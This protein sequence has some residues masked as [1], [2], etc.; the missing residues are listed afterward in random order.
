MQPRLRSQHGPSYHK[1]QGD[2]SEQRL[3]IEIVLAGFSDDPWH[4]TLVGARVSERDVDFSLL[5][6]D[7]IAIVADADD[8]LQFLCHGAMVT[9][10]PITVNSRQT[11]S[12]SAGYA[13]LT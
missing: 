12:G 13:S 7:G 8:Q 3:R 1:R 9:V 2:R 4:A 11:C 5:Q 6:S 10:S